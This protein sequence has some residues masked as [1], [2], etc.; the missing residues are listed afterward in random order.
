M[1]GSQQHVGT[2]F[3]VLVTLVVVVMT[4]APR[5][6]HFTMVGLVLVGWPSTSPVRSR[7]RR[8]R[9]TAARLAKW[10]GVLHGEPTG[11]G[12]PNDEGE[13]APAESF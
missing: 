9:L 4:L 3:V 8:S 5:G 13:E 10:L 1:S 12:R 11:D 6:H 7:A 2:L